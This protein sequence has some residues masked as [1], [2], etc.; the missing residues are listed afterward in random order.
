VNAN[1]GKE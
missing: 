1:L